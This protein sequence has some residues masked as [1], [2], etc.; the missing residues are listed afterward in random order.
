M[1]NTEWVKWFGLIIAIIALGLVIWMVVRSYTIPL[2]VY[3]SLTGATGS[4][5][6]TGDK[7]IPGLAANTG[8]TGS[9][10]PTGPTGISPTGPTGPTGYSFTGPIGPTGEPGTLSEEADLTSLHVIGTSLIAGNSFDIG[11]SEC[12]FDIE[13]GVSFIDTALKFDFTGDLNQATTIDW[14]VSDPN[15]V[16]MDAWGNIVLPTTRPSWNVRNA[17]GSATLLRIDNSQVHVPSYPLDVPWGLGWYKIQVGN[18]SNPPW[19]LCSNSSKSAHFSSAPC[20]WA[21]EPSM[22]RLRDSYGNC[23]VGADDLMNSTADCSDTRTV[24]FNLRQGIALQ[25]QGRKCLDTSYSNDRVNCAKCQN[26]DNPPWANQAIN[27][28]LF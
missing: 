14:R 20:P 26:Y 21:I 10:G 8:S 5:G 19:Y 13:E 23:L 12:T 9:T 22:Q 6:P 25:Y 18:A 27:I 3:P 4:T 15:A 17:D 1:A 11:T 7:G 2:T 24:G 16:S 28:S